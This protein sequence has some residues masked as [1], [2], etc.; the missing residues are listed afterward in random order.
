M[1]NTPCSTAQTPSKKR[2]LS[3]ASTNID[4]TSIND[5]SATKSISN[6]SGDQV[7]SGQA[8]VDDSILNNEVYK[9]YCRERDP[10]VARKKIKELKN[11]ILFQKSTEPFPDEKAFKSACDTTLDRLWKISPNSSDSK[12][13]KIKKIID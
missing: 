5:S 13:D 3:L 2:K 4:E 6:G 9:I 8:D 10:E 7:N 11:C 12:F 1:P